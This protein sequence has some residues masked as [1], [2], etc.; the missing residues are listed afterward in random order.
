MQYAAAHFT[1]LSLPG[2]QQCYQ[3]LQ[4][5]PGYS[6][7]H[8]N[9][10]PPSIFVTGVNS[11]PG[12]QPMDIVSADFMTTDDN[13]NSEGLQNLGIMNDT[14]DAFLFYAVSEIAASKRPK[15]IS[16]RNASEPQMIH[17]PFPDT[18]KP[19]QIIDI[20]KGMAG[21]IYGIY[22]YCTTLNSAFACWGVIAGL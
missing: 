15:C 12:P 5:T 11:V 21:S 9:T 22:Q 8:E 13:N 4:L 3:R 2:L 1:S 18:T 10:L 16:V 20:L 6:F 17:A 14:D 7:V 19:S